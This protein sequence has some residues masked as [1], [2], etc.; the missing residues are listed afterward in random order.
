MRVLLEIEMI[1]K[2]IRPL[3]IISLITAVLLIGLLA[4]LSLYMET[5][6]ITATKWVGHTHQVLS[7]IEKF[8][9]NLIRAESAQR[10]YF[11]LHVPSFLNER[12]SALTMAR[13]DIKEIEALTRDNIKQIN[14]LS[15]LKDLLAQRV[16]MFIKT[17]TMGDTSGSIPAAHYFVEGADISTRLQRVTDNMIDEENGLLTAREAKETQSLRF[18]HASFIL[19]GASLTLVLLLLARRILRDIGVQEQAI[20]VLRLSRDELET[21]T[22]YQER[23]LRSEALVQIASRA[24]HIGGWMAD[25]KTSRVSWSD[26]V[27]DIYDVPHGTSHTVADA[28]QYCMGKGRVTLT[29]LF[30]TC[31]SDGTA[32]DYEVQILTAKQRQVWVRIIGEAVRDASNLVVQIQG[33]IQ[34][35]TERKSSEANAVRQAELL[36]TTLESITDAFVM[37]DRKWNFKYL[38]HEA[39]RLLLISSDEVLGTSLWGIFSEAVGGQYAKEYR[40]AIEKNCSVAFEEYHAA[41]NVWMEIRAYP[42]EEGLA[43]YFLDITQRKAM[44]GELHTL[45]FYDALTGLPNR[46]LLLNRIE[47]AVA[48]SKRNG[49]FGA[50]LFIDLDNFKGINDTQGHDEGDTLLRLVASR[51]KEAVRVSDTVARLGGD[52]FIILLEDLAATE[53]EAAANAKRIAE[54]TLKSFSRPFEI[55]YREHYSSA[56]I[57]IAIFSGLS[58]TFDDVLKQADLAMYQSK[59]AGR[60]AMSFFLPEMQAMVSARVAMI[61]DLRHALTKNE[62]ILYYQPQSDMHGQ[63]TGTEALVRWRHPVRGFVQPVDFIPI[64]EETGLILPLGMWVLNTACVQLARWGKSEETEMLSMSVNVSAYQ[65]HSLEFVDQVADILKETGANPCRLKLELTESLLINDVEET[66]GKMHVLKDMG[67]GFSLDDF[68]TGYSSLSYL[69]RL[70][71]TEVKID[72]AFIRDFANEQQGTIIIRMIIALGKAF[73]LDVVAEGVETSEQYAFVVEEG[74]KIYQGYLYSKPLP[75]TELDAFIQEWCN[76]SL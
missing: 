22:Q 8:Q 40:L 68:G 14:A 3:V 44:E 9:N 36:T 20:E 1:K 71:L 29:H 23:M 54:K 13:V 37:V 60:N 2:S 43:I 16:A 55:A 57:G 45:A 70:P 30:D 59:A 73:N 39:E 28:A 56:S 12:E 25:L 5:K 74:C 62:F 7:T 66:I 35:I 10:G 26:E 33:G 15:M 65:F 52:E 58:T 48:L 64:A 17:Q 18:A 50:V 76:V 38:N 31:I 75:K 4:T 53:K 51:L 6:L 49:R 41:L 21:K 11:V 46:Q 72:K 19:L 69:Q 61:A 63:M 42:S 32:Y 34:D 47:K 27:C 24:A 67:I